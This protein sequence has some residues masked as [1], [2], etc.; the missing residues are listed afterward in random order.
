MIDALPKTLNIAV[1]T[2]SIDNSIS[3]PSVSTASG[4]NAD[5]DAKLALVELVPSS[6]TSGDDVCDDV[7]ESVVSSYPK[8]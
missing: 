7:G 2:G 5:D 1:G 6:I 3:W 8:L 4:N